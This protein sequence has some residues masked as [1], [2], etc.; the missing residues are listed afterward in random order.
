MS[1][2]HAVPT[3][4]LKRKCGS[5][6]FAEQAQNVYGGSKCYIECTYAGNREQWE[7]R[8]ISAIRPRSKRACQYYTQINRKEDSYEQNEANA[9]Q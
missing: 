1:K 9:L 7:E 3:T 4:D 2:Y 8:R 6:A 5:C